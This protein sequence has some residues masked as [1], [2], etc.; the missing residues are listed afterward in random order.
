MV[1]TKRECQCRRRRE[2]PICIRYAVTDISHIIQGIRSITI[3]SV[4]FGVSRQAQ[5]IIWELNAHLQ[6]LQVNIVVLVIRCCCMIICGSQSNV[7]IDNLKSAGIRHPLVFQYGQPQI[8]VWP[9]GLQECDNQLVKQRY[10]GPAKVLHPIWRK[11]LLLDQFRVLIPGY[12][13]PAGI[14]PGYPVKHHGHAIAGLK[15]VKGDRYHWRYPKVPI[16]ATQGRTDIPI[17]PML[18]HIWHVTVCPIHLSVAG[19][20]VSVGGHV[21]FIAC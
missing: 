11:L 17:L 1:L 9:V 21:L 3:P 16:L 8:P 20:A 2:A 13:K 7:V 15:P 12:F 14:I 19:Q 10:F 18:Q 6:V 5:G 4:H